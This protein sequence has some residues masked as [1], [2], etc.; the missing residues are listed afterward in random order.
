[1]TVGNIVA[2][3]GF[4]NIEPP[5]NHWEMNTPRNLCLFRYA[6]GDTA[7][8]PCKVM[9]NGASVGTVAFPPTGSFTTYKTVTLPVNLGAANGFREVR[10]TSTTA[11]GGPNLDQIFMQ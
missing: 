2:H 9:V 11:T 7:N 1:M 6:K 3:T 10:V 5:N 4:S 8:R